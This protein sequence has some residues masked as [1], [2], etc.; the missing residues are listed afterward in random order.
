MS[1]DS[2]SFAL[3][4]R[5]FQC[6]GVRAIELDPDAES[7]RQLSG[8]GRRYVETLPPDEAIQAW[9]SNRCDC[10]QTDLAD[11]AAAVSDLQDA[12]H[13][14]HHVFPL[15]KAGMQEPFTGTHHLTLNPQ[16]G[17]IA[18]VWWRGRLWPVFWTPSQVLTL[19][20]MLKTRTGIEQR[21]SQNQKP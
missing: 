11:Q 3:V 9:E 2:S 17:V 19:D 7:H 6:R 16:G 10:F 12:L 15:H 14:L 21:V 5:C 8:D 13:L 4:A 20:L 1:Q 18:N